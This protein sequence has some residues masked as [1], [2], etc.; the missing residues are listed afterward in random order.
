MKLYVAF[1]GLVF[2]L[3]CAPTQTH[4]PQPLEPASP[5]PIARPQVNIPPD[6]L[7]KLPLAVQAAYLSGQSASVRD[8]FAI[9]YPYHPYDEPTVR[10]A[11]SHVTEIVLSPDEQ[12]VSATVGDSTRWMLEPNLNHVRVKP[13]PQGCSNAGGAAA[14]QPVPNAPRFF[15]TNLIID[16]NRPRTYHINLLAG[17][18]THAME[19]FAFWYPDDIAAAQQARA[20]A[21]RKSAQQVADPPAHLNFA[22]R[23]TGPNVPW[24]PLQA[25][26]DGSHEYLLFA[27][28]ASLESDMPSLY[29]QEGKTQALA[30]YEVRGSYYVVDR[31]YADAAL[32]EGEGTNRQTVRI[33]ALAH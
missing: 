4:Q 8:G 16:T 9:F 12:V 3:G 22:Y 30:N 14:G 18:P 31:L 29:V 33:Q 10:T 6:P 11:P 5:A 25:F 17:P 1:L 24:R 23:I 28:N 20:A 19:T 13:C 7:A 15:N 27:S 32:T 21:I 2:F 26:D